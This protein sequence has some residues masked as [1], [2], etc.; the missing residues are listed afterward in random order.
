MRNEVLETIQALPYNLKVKNL[1]HKNNLSA[2]GNETLTGER[3]VTL[4]VGGAMHSSLNHVYNEDIFHIK[5]IYVHIK[6]LEY[7]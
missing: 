2:Y 3:W 7:T 1:N 5:F 6:I 4:L